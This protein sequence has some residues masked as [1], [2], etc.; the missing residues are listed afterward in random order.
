MKKKT[1]KDIDVAGKR[2]FVRVDFN[3]PQDD[4]GKITDD[5]TEN[6]QTAKQIRE[7]DHTVVDKGIVESKRK[8][9][10]VNDDL[11]ERKNSTNEFTNTEQYLEHIYGYMNKDA[12]E[13]L[14]KYRKT[15]LNIDLQII[16]ELEDLFMHLW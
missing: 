13:L 2:V 7:A 9:G 12:S 16:D 6:T 5:T 3:V 14:M 1:F 15:F 10:T 4:S 8:D 11:D